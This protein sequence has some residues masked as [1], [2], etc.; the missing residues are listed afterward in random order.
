MNKVICIQGNFFASK[1]HSKL[2]ITFKVDSLF[3]VLYYL[4]LIRKSIVD[5]VFYPDVLQEDCF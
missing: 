1:N 3:I 4:N 5:Q 2:L